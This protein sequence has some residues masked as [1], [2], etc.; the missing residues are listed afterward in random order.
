[1]SGK[2]RRFRRGQV[3]EMRNRLVCSQSKLKKKEEALKL[4]SVTKERMM[5]VPALP[6]HDDA[7]LVEKSAG[8]VEKICTTDNPR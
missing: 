7:P 8:G 4:E 5:H 6:A 3:F 2:L 1:M